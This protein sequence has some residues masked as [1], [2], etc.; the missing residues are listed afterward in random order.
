[1]YNLLLLSIQTN[2]TL[3]QT[4][5]RHTYNFQLFSIQANPTVSRQIHMCKLSTLLHPSKSH[6]VTTDTHV[7]LSTLLHP[8]KL[9]L[10]TNTARDTSTTS[11]SSPSK[12][13]PLCHN[14]DTCTTCYSSPSKQTPQNTI[15]THVQLVSKPHCV[16]VKTHAQPT[17]LL[18]PS[19]PHRA[20]VETHVQPTT[21]LHQR[22]IVET[23][24]QPT[25]L[26]HPS[27]PHGVT[28]TTST[29]IHVQLATSCSPSSS[30]PIQP[31][32]P[33]AFGTCAHASHTGQTSGGQTSR[34][35][36]SRYNRKAITSL[37][38]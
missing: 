6:R 1:M 26:L 33:T 8:S 3:T 36:T 10:D 25:T 23:H 34:P 13:T 11:N 21:L 30:N 38:V 16:T 27:K 18:H 7:Q 31:P 4:Q 5:Q 24:V 28:R 20:T 22:V 19:K 37:S 9:H 12:Q 15:K 35:P 14:R 29:Y 2:S 17:T 32:A